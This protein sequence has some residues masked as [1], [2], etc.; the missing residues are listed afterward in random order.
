M[1]NKLTNDGQ[2]QLLEIGLRGG[3]PLTVLKFGLTNAA[4]TLTSN[5]AAAAAGEP[6]VAFGYDRVTVTQD[7]TGWPTDAATG[8][9]WQLTSEDIVWTASGGAIEPFSKVFM[10]DDTL[11]LAFWD[12]ATATIADT[13]SFTFVAR[14]KAT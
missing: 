12:V 13:D 6:A 4:L 8:L 1:S 14:V 2:Q 10:T 7:G 9:G 3:T 11:L 5:L